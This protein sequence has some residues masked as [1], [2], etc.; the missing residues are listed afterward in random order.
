VQQHDEA[1]SFGGLLRAHRTNAG[2][3][4]E[5]LAERAGLSRRGIADLERGARLAPYANTVERLAAA[6]GLSPTDQ[7]ALV[8]AARRFGRSA[9]STHAN[10]RPQVPAISPEGL[11]A[12]VDASTKHNL[13][14]QPTSFIGREQ[15]L[16]QV[17]M[18]LASS[19]LVTLVG[20]GGVGKTRLALE[21]ALAQVGN[22]PD[23]V[24]LVEL[25]ALAE[26]DLL[27][28]SIALTVG[29]REAP[30]H[31]LLAHLVGALAGRK[32]LL[33]LDNC[34]HLIETCARTAEELI[35]HCP[36]VH[37]LATSRAP[38][39]VHGEREFPV[40]PLAL[41]D[42]ARPGSA[43]GL[44]HYGAVVLFVERARSIRPEFVLSADNA[45]AVARICVRLDGLPL[46]I[47]LAAARIR[48]LSPQAMLARLEHRL[49]LLTGGARY[50]PARQ[51]TLSAAIGWSYDLLEERERA[52]FRRL[53]IFVG[54]CTLEAAEAVVDAAG[55]GVD[56][57][58]G[59]ASLVA[60]SL[61]RQ[62]DGVDGEPRLM[63]LETIREFGLER[64]QAS[65]EDDAT[66]QRYAA[67][68][69]ALV[70]EAEPKL[71]GAEQVRWIRSLVSEY[72]N[73][74]AVL[75]LSRDGLI[76]GEVG[77]RVVGALAMF[78][79]FR[80]FA[81]EAREWT[82]AMLALPAARAPTA[83]RARAL[84]AAAHAARL[85]SDSSVMGEFAA[86]SE[87]IFRAV[88]DDQRAGRSAAIVGLS[89]EQAI[90]YD[91]A[92]PWLA[93]SAR[94]AERAG[95][96][97]GLAFALSQ[98][99][100]LADYQ[101]APDEALRLRQ[102]S[103][104][105]ARRIGER[106]TLGLALSGLARLARDRG[107]HKESVALFKEALTVSSELE[108][109]WVLPRALA[110]L[111]GAAGLASDYA[112]SARLLG[113]VA[114]L[115]EADGTREH[116]QWRELFEADAQVIRA[117]LGGTAFEAAWT[118]GHAMTLEQVVAYATSGPA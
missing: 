55:L 62:E 66:R 47:E 100:A 51:Q 26:P 71:L 108:D 73:L 98:L 79:N 107:D 24:W 116:V 15:E 37:V 99:G 63:M 61:V 29:I 22:W 67:F 19:R 30:G 102:A 17:G 40:P 32:L 109:H 72:D 52:L 44:S 46:A 35:R 111:A 48:V 101:G 18:L 87:K 81:R 60:K 86:E 50:R 69:V 27:S 78:W 75:A 6:L 5:E 118:E 114:A 89:H 31:S 53:S 36:N 23:G 115:R 97:W 110:G 106:R 57:L 34:E 74:R 112:R 59:A 9:P 91:A 95:D 94:L 4:Q 83:A 88:G 80:G 11:M 43:N 41:P 14:L 38:L 58:D 33:V 56:I 113:A 42:P 39:E 103:A 70:E 117:A 77:L 96:Q 65:G 105:L 16:A 8:E 76:A 10:R 93:E 12:E 21:V 82:E 64:L 13:A 85:H 3:T 7:A 68:F 20:T 1:Q 92:Y 28:Q 2:L 45:A 54:G 49:Q 104:D 90:E 84:Y 25:A